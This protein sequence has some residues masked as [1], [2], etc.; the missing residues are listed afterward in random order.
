MSSEILLDCFETIR[1]VE[2]E[3]GDRNGLAFIVPCNEV[4]ITEHWRGKKGDSQTDHFYVVSLYNGL[5]FPLFG[6]VLKLFH[7]YG[8]TPSQLA[9]NAWRIL[10]TFYLG[11]HVI[12]V[13][14][15]SRLFRYFY[16]LK[17]HEK[18]Y[19]LQSRGKLI[20]IKLLNTNKG[21]MET[22]IH[23]DHQSNWIWDRS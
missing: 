23:S 22:L 6:F 7:D 3:E 5:R 13:A 12:G 1:A 9:P 10:A 18:F 8:V 19:F 11:C 21:W 4:W 15:T 2:G 20:M 14:P 16:F 17:S